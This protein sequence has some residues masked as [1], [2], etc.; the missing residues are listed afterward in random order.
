MT[1]DDLDIAIRAMLRRR[2]FQTFSIEFMSGTRVLVSH[3]ESIV[4][5][6]SLFLHRGPDFAY[7]IFNG[8]SVCQLVEVM[9]TPPS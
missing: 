9:P 1:N 7:R 8:A 5:Q 4:G 6:G 3:P 2:P